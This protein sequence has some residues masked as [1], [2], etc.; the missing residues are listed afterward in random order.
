MAYLFDKKINRVNDAIRWVYPPPKYIDGQKD[1]IRYLNALL[2][3]EYLGD[4]KI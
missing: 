3:F 2:I 4:K 1:N